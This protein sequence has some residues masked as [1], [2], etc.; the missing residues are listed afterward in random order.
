MIDRRQ[1]LG[2]PPAFGLAATAT[3]G[4]GS[5]TFA[6]VASLQ[7]DK[8]QA[9]PND[10]VEAQGFRY[11]VAGPEAL[12]H[13]L[14]TAGGVKLYVLPGVDGFNVL[15]FGARGNYSSRT[16]RGADDTVPIQ[17]A[18]KAA[19]QTGLPV[20]LPGRQYRVTDTLSILNEDSLSSF[21]IR[22]ENG[23]S[24]RIWFDNEV[25]L[26]NL[27]FCDTKISYLQVEHIEVLDKNP[28]TSRAL[29][30]TGERSTG[31]PTWKHFF[32]DI[33]VTAF[34]EG[35]RFNGGT[36]FTDDA[37]LDGI[38]FL[39]SKFRNCRKSLIYN[40]IQAVSHQLIGV[41]F[42]NDAPEDAT[43]MWPMIVLERG[44]FINHV[45]GGAIGSG[46]YLLFT[47]PRAGGAFQ[48]T[49]Q[50]TSRGV[51]AE[52]RGN[53]VLIDHDP[54]SC[55]SVGNSLRVIVEDMGVIV[56][57]NSAPVFARFGG[58]VYAKFENVHANVIMDVQ[59]IM[60]E[61]LSS[62]GAQ[63]FIE[64]SRCKN[65]V[66]KR[67]GDR[68]AYQNEAVPA[69][70]LGSIPAEIGGRIEGIQGASINGY[71]NLFE[72]RQTVYSGGFQQT[73]P[74]TIVFASSD[75]GGF[76][77][78]SN[79]LALLVQVPLYARPFK[80]RLLKDRVNSASEF[81]FNLYAV[82][83][84]LECL[85]ATIAPRANV[86]GHYE[87]DIQTEEGLVNFLRD[88]VTWDGRMKIEL[89]G[90]ADGFVGLIMIDYM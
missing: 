82:L 39:H 88:D 87:A 57:N 86:A 49:S 52:L 74:K 18:I 29:L 65:L 5:S 73:E 62:S 68:D 27:F 78:G 54:N 79:S 72:A 22:G 34:A 11:Q 85:V 37:Y 1:F 12:D 10:I 32:N 66:Y 41:D 81:V 40:N 75:V 3:E 2:V 60:T 8:A 89:T 77:N 59:G 56:S 43:E 35:V 80:F 51:K 42:E 58:R 20:H 63:G 14:T 45:G 55:I 64:I 19:M 84:G 28:G 76:G 70:N 53:G 6:T 44:T 16:A 7:A 69:A 46:A 30:M 25:P 15:A 33:R 21:S 23:N 71:Y 47:Y 13:H 17:T 61:E 24:T 38:M 48:T 83:Q 67:I 36:K 26:K 50:F 4:L 9:L 90:A 31:W